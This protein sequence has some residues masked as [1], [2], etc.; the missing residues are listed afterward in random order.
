MPK[1]APPLFLARRAYRRRRM[2][3]GARL[4]P[5]LGAVLVMIP[6]L[7]QPDQT[8]APD[9][10]RGAVYIFGVWA[11]LI[12]AAMAMSKGL[13]AAMSDEDEDAETGR[14]TGHDTA[15]PV[16]NLAA[17]MTGSYLDQPIRSGRIA[18]P[19]LP[20]MPPEASR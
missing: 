5:L 15:T 3:D 20:P 9:T 10:A 19:P 17:N 13:C 11:A 12:L 7:W 4:L 1:Q 14:D 6:A 8:A 18:V 2:M 16:E